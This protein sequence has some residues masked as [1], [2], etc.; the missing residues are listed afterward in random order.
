MKGK[1]SYDSL[2]LLTGSASARFTPDIETHDQGRLS[3]A[4]PVRIGSV[5]GT[6]RNAGLSGLR[7]GPRLPQPIRPALPMVLVPGAFR[8]ESRRLPDPETDWHE[9]RRSES[10][11]GLTACSD[12]RT[13]SCHCMC[14]CLALL[15]LSYLRILRNLRFIRR[16]NFWAPDGRA[17]LL[18]QAPGSTSTV[19]RRTA[20]GGPGGSHRSAPLSRQPA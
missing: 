13:S 8:L 15:F 2:V 12:F 4:A 11:H 19:S 20:P 6:G 10:P 17:S 1:S 9:S 3:R 14:P 18:G 16:S 7:R 5:T